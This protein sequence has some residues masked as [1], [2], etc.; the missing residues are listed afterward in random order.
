M[1]YG[2]VLLSTTDQNEKIKS[3]AFGELVTCDGKCV[4]ATLNKRLLHVS[5]VDSDYEQIVSITSTDKLEEL[6]Q[7]PGPREPVEYLAPSVSGVR[8]RVLLQRVTQALVTVDGETVV[9]IGGGLL[10]FVGV[11]NE[12]TETEIDWLVERKCRSRTRRIQFLA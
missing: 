8:M 9:R 1:K 12:D 3:A 2:Y 4:V 6:P 10:V 11:E 7:Q 5:I